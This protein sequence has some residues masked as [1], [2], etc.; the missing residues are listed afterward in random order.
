MDGRHCRLWGQTP[1]WRIGD[2]PRC[3]E[4]GTDLQSQKR[5]LFKRG[6]IPKGAGAPKQGTDPGDRPFSVSARSRSIPAFPDVD[7][8]WW[9]VT[10]G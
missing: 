5:V 3:G 1:M 4:L 8:G 9:L 6:Q 7:G 10:S 2:R